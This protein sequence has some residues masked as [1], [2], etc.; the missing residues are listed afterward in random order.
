MIEVH[1]DIWEKGLYKDNT[2][3]CIPTNLGWKLDGT[4]VMGKGL[5]HQA[6]KKF[7]WLSKLYGEWCKE[8]DRNCLIYKEIYYS[9]DPYA[10][11]YLICIPT[12]P[13]DEQYPYL[14][15]RQNSDLKL[16]GESLKQLKTVVRDL[17]LNKVF[18]PMLGC[19]NGGLS[20]DDVYPLLGRHLM[21][22]RYILVRN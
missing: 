14:S 19:G 22:D 21:D 10:P 9:K 3:I 17:K 1:G 12:K 16:I 5:A 20:E 2:G 8:R 11:A 15:W 4:N 18:I 7:E 13:L 6:A